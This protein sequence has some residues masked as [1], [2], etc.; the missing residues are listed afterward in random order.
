MGGKSKKYG[1]KTNGFRYVVIKFC[2][3]A[4][5]KTIVL[6]KDKAF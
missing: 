3:N 5:P 4:A 6:N 2:Y 1:S